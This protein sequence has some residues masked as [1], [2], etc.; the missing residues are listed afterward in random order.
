MTLQNIYR[1]W[2]SA[3]WSLVSPTLHTHVSLAKGPL[4][5]DSPKALRPLAHGLSSTDLHDGNDVG[6]GGLTSTSDYVG[7]DSSDGVYSS[8]S[9]LDYPVF[10][11]LTLTDDRRQSLLIG[12]TFVCI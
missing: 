4:L 2:L 6:H 1:L 11:V 12:L 10:T 5:Y 8:T 7:G 3:D 9:S